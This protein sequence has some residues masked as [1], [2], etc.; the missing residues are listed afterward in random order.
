MNNLS[1]KNIERKERWKEIITNLPSIMT[2][3]HLVSTFPCNSCRAHRSFTDLKMRLWEE[4]IK[5]GRITVFTLTEFLNAFTVHWV[6]TKE[7]FFPI[8]KECIKT[9]REHA[10]TISK[11]L[12]VVV[13]PGCN[14]KQIDFFFIDESL[15][16][17]INFSPSWHEKRLK[18]VVVSSNAWGV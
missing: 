3:H 7:H 9:L 15:K 12:R 4:T 2:S 17:V 8:E 13:L 1:L 6:K 10:F 16:A 11:S 14:N 5:K 18:A